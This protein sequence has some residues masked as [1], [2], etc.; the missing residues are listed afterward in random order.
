MNPET[1]DTNSKILYDA[2]KSNPDV[3]I[4][5]DFL[6]K[7]TYFCQINGHIFIVKGTSL[8][9]NDVAVA[10]LTKDKMITKFA[11]THYGIR[12]ADGFSIERGKEEVTEEVLRNQISSFINKHGKIIAKPRDG[13]E[14]KYIFP[15]I[16]NVEDALAAYYQINSVIRPSGENYSGVLFEEQLVGDLYRFTVTGGKVAAIAIRDFAHV[17]GDGQKTVS[18]L[19]TPLRKY[20]SE[21]RLQNSKDLPAEE[22]PITINVLKQQGLSWASIPETGVRVTITEIPS[23]GYIVNIASEKVNPAIIRKIEAFCSQTRLKHAGFDI[24]TP[25]LSGEDFAVIEIN[26]LPEIDLHFYPDEGEGI[27]V[28]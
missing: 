20:Y 14:S 7:K 26:G 24:M 11:L 1:L 27:N 23:P 12:T 21:D 17:F 6:A 8:P 5:S 15:N 25:D 28:A 19:F 18:E 2:L 3:E 16:T 4:I 13:A 10:K 22:D 9:F